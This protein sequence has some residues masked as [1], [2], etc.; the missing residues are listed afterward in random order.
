VRREFERRLAPAAW[1]GARALASEGRLG[2][3]LLLYARAL[4]HPG[5]LGLLRATLNGRPK[6]P[7]KRP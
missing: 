5:G 3:A 6:R 7:A 1:D 4:L 2:A